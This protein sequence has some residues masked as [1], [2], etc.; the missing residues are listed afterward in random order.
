MGARARRPQVIGDFMQAVYRDL[1]PDGTLRAAI[2]DA[3]PVLVQRDAASGEHCGLAV[4]LV[5]DLAAR[6][7]VPRSLLFYEGAV[8]IFEARL[9]G[10]WD[11]AFLAI[12][13]V[14]AQG[15]DFTAPFVALEGTYLVRGTSPFRTAIDLDHPGVRIVVGQGTVYDS[16]LTRHL[17]HAELIRTHTT[18]EALQRFLSEELDAMAG[19]KQPLAAFAQVTPGLHVIEGRFAA[20]QQ[21]IA[22]PKGRSAGLR[23]L[24]AFVDEIKDSQRV[25]RALERN[26]VLGCA[27]ALKLA[28][29]DA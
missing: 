6:L 14:R 16:H 26:G 1:C 13:P 19:L 9:A 22:V 11:I 24:K 21:A 8:S 23:Y 17:H 4:D 29:P 5:D 2:N 28:R 7:S 27:A 15:V 18:R 25:V 12:D 20:I 3:N 10:E